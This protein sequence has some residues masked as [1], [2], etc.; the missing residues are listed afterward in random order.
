VLDNRD[1]SF[2]VIPIKL[3][4]RAVDA[5]AYALENV[6]LGDTDKGENLVDVGEPEDARYDGILA[7]E[8]LFVKKGKDYQKRGRLE[9]PK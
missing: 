3:S 5:W 1:E 8:A 7:L 4:A 9:R 6:A 2:I